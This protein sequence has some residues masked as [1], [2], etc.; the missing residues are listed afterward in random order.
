[1]FA[2]VLL[3]CSVIDT[4]DLDEFKRGFNMRVRTGTSFCNVG[5]FKLC[6]R[7]HYL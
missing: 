3:G 5:L 4:P 2:S 6:V 1:M 7:L